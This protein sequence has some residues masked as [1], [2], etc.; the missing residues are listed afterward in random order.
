MVHNDHGHTGPAYRPKGLNMTTTVSTHNVTSAL[1]RSLTTSLAELDLRLREVRSMDLK[2]REVAYVLF[3]HCGQVVGD[4]D[5]RPN[6]P[7][8]LH[9]ASHGLDAARRYGK[10][11][12]KRAAADWN[13][14]LTPTQRAEKCRVSV[15][16]LEAA[17][18]RAIRNQTAILN[19]LGGE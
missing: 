2:P 13:R 11:Q 19:A 9:E 7:L 8:I 14:N 6:S 16:T 12:A 4:V 15:M 18:D 3:S 10:S 1:R 17:L 5:H